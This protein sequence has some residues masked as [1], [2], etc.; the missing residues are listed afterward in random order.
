MEL[1]VFWGTFA[2]SLVALTSL[3]VSRVEVSVLR[4]KLL[5]S[6][7]SKAAAEQAAAIQAAAAPPVALV[8]DSAPR[9]AETDA[10]ELPAEA[11]AEDDDAGDAELEKAE[12]DE[13]EEVDESQPAVKKAKV[14]MMRFLE[15]SL[16]GLL[17]GGFKLDS[18]SKFGCHLFLAGAAE[19]IGRANSLGHGEFVKVLETSVAVLGSGP[20]VAQKFGE[21]YDE[22]LL[23]PDYAKI[24]RAGGQAMD[25][26][27]GG[28][29]DPGKALAQALDEFKKPDKKSD[30]IIAVL[31][32]DIVGS[33]KL[34]QTLGDAGAQKVVH[35]HNT[36][37]RTALRE[38][39]G[40]EVKHTGDGI[41]AS[42]QSCADAVQGAVTMQRA[43][44]KQREKDPNTALHIR[45]GV[46]A[47]EPIK[48]DGDLFGTTVQLAA[49]ICDKADT[50]GIY[51][52]PIVREL[53]QGLGVQFEDRGKFELKGVSEPPTLY[54]VAFRT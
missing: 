49:R 18:V 1:I 33:T 6:D 29:G 27:S 20:E 16:T 25:R 24:F 32:T 2:V 7:E 48:E 11:D 42:F 4:F 36:V 23:E 47:G 13:E 46:N 41:M 44:D 40:N 12:E 28:D 26:F 5:E 35:L 34:T 39:R 8:K 30:G 50:D 53:S 37:V 54:A 38:H 21:K 19:S 3:F 43:L 22:Y 17:K 45:I 14:E 31:F 52:S 10:P 9:P 15:G 51:I